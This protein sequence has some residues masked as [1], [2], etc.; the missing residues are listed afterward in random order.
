V[1]LIVNLF[2]SPGAGKSTMALG[3]TYELKRAKMDVELASEYAKDMT[4]DG[5]WDTLKDQ[6]YMFA[7]QRARLERLTKHC[8]VVVTDCPLLMGAQYYPELFPD[9][10]RELLVWAFDQH[11]TLNLFLTRTHTYSSHGRR[12]TQEESDAISK[13]MLD[14]LDKNKVDYHVITGDDAGLEQAQR[15]IDMRL[16]PEAYMHCD[17]YDDVTDEEPTSGPNLSSWTDHDC[18]IGCGRVMCNCQCNDVG[19]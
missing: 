1:T 3:L 4:F 19:C 15:L 13:E 8:D 2:G 17:E 12:Q 16:H 11:Q 7:K 5:R 18:C 6:I 9:C 14:F 10:F